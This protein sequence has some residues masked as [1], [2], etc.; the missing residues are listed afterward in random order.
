MWTCSSRPVARVRPL[1]NLLSSLPSRAATRDSLKRVRPFSSG[2]GLATNRINRLTPRDSILPSTI[3]R[4]PRP[5]THYWLSPCPPPLGPCGPQG[6]SARAPDS[7]P[8]GKTFETVKERGCFTPA[9]NEVN[10]KE[11]ATSILVSATCSPSTGACRK[12]CAC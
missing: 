10:V 4:S 11:H 6:D 5:A 9:R 2:S 1:P 12:N 7:P 3:S 8:T